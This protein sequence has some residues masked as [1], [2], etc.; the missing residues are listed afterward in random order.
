MK[1]KK[2]DASKAGLGS[3]RPEGQG[4]TN[5]ETGNVKMDS[6]RRRPRNP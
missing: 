6:T 3:P 4:T 2:Q 5:T 1:R